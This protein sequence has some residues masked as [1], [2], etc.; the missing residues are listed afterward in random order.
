MSA[1]YLKNEQR[2]HLKL[3]REKSPE[4]VVELCKSAFEYLTNGPNS[5]KYDLLAKKH[6]TS[7]EQVRASIEALI[8]LLID[9]T[10]ANVT[11]ED[12]ENLRKDGFSSDHVAILMQFVTSKR[13]F[14]ESSIKWANIKSYR[15]INLEWRLEVKISSRSLLNQT[16]V[17]VTMK[18]NLHTEP[19]SENR[20]LINF[21]DNKIVHENEAKNRKDIIVQTDI[22]NLLHI[23]DVLEQ[24][25]LESKSRRI[26]NLVEAIH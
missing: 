16:T 14:V 1:F 12:F 17:M 21:E 22:N 18:L 15:L 8:C 6:S 24:A 20:E 10:K 5:T 23:I 11:D 13:P 7:P 26:R 2:E 3:V 19:K 25:M 9:A 4:D